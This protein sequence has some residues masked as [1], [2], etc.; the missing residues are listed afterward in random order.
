MALTRKP[1]VR[2]I[3]T[4]LDDVERHFEIYGSLEH[5]LFSKMLCDYLASCGFIQ[6]ANK[7]S[8][9]ITIIGR[10]PVSITT[11]VYLPIISR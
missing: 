10:K 8:R 7:S 11:T 9:V 6:P 4:T 3:Q 5:F 2:N 1:H